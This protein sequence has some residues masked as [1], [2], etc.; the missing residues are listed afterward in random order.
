M[1]AIVLSA[2]YGTRLGELTQE[3]PKA[4]LPVADRPLVEHILLNLARHGFD[5]VAVNLHYRPELVQDA[6]GD[7]SRL[8][9]R[10]EYSYEPELLGTAGT[11]ASLRGFLGDGPFLVHYGDVLTNE[12]LGALAAEHQ[13]RGALLT[14]LVHERPGSNSV[15]V[16]DDERRIVEFAER[17]PADDPVRERSSW[18]NSGICV[19]DPAVLDLVPPAPSDLAR[20]LLPALA[21]RPDV[22]ARPL[23]RRRI[24]VDSPDRYRQAVTLVEEGW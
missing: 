23:T 3:L 20:D 4:L 8:G 18:T 19:C 10:I 9:V 5:E 7:G 11:L 22:Y 2:G 17:P 1:R 13:A 21:G 12:D 24:A 16:L 6:L 15:V 14:L